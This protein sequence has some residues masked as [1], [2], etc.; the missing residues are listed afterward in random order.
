[1]ETTCW[2]WLRPGHRGRRATLC[3][4]KGEF[5]LSMLEGHTLL[6]H[7]IF[8]NTTELIQDEFHEWPKMPPAKATIIC[9]HFVER[10]SCM[11][12]RELNVPKSIL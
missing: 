7:F 8:C 1:M 9:V 5:K 4:T 6:V 3:V 2:K 12:I 11:G 10:N